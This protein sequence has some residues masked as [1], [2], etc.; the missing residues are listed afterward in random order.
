[1][2]LNYDHKISSDHF[3]P[4]FLYESADG[5]LDGSSMIINGKRNKKSL[6]K[7][8]RVLFYICAS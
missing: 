3:C 2:P 1:M 8:Y 4:I 5:D 6:Y 7:I